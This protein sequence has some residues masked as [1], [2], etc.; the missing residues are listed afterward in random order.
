MSSNIVILIA[1]ALAVLPAVASGDALAQ[2]RP[3]TATMRCADVQRLVTSRGSVVLS[4]GPFVYDLYVSNGAQCPSN[5][6]AIYAYERTADDAQCRIG[7]R[8]SSSFG[9]GVGGGGTNR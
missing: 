3:D 5:R 4:T 1:T 8:C 6:G 2:A 9:G 7:Y